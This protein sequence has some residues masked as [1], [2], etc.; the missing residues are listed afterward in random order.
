MLSQ[1]PGKSPPRVRLCDRVRVTPLP[2][3]L[4]R[5]TCN[6]WFERDGFAWATARARITAPTRSDISLFNV[7]FAITPV[8]PGA[9]FSDVTWLEDGPRQ[10]IS[11][12]IK[13]RQSRTPPNHEH[14]SRGFQRSRSLSW[15]GKAGAGTRSVCGPSKK[16]DTGGGA[17]RRAKPTFIAANRRPYLGEWALSFP[18]VLKDGTSRD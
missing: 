9:I 14:L 1:V 12:D 16:Q 15:P 4:R 7:R 18:R 10:R 3:R 13:S 5:L 8:F 11:P 17:C 6:I 2:R